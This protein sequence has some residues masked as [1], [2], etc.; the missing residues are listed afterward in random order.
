MRLHDTMF[1]EISIRLYI[2]KIVMKKKSY[3]VDASLR[4]ELL[5]PSNSDWQDK[6]CITNSIS[7]HFTQPV[8]FRSRKASEFNMKAWQLF[9]LR[10]SRWPRIKRMWT[11]DECAALSQ[12]CHWGTYIEN[13]QRNTSV[14]SSVR[15]F[16][17][18]Y[19]SEYNFKRK[20]FVRN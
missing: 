6:N 15:N 18:F 19:K 11:L 9:I 12:H 14:L 5:L 16:T 17:S 7:C 8:E 13:W 4:V 3:H 10:A 20:I 1:H 2:A